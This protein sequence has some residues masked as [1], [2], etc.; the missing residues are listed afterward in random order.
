MMCNIKQSPALLLHLSCTAFLVIPAYG[1]FGIF[2]ILQAKS[3][4]NQK[5]M[6]KILLLL[7][8]GFEMYETSAF[9][10]VIGWN[11]VYGTKDTKLVTCGL[12]KR[13]RSTFSIPIEV[14]VLIDNVN[15]EDFSALA[16]PGGFEVYGYYND[17]YSDKFSS[18]I[19][20]FDRAGK[21]IASICVGALPLAN[22]G[23]LKYRNATTYNCH[24]KQRMEQLQEYN[25]YVL[26]QE[27]V[28]DKNVITSSSPGTAMNVAFKFLEKITD[29]KNTNYIKK[30]MGFG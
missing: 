23:I 16:V 12:R 5:P 17:A 30:I 14:D 6:K 9:I 28:L 18:L 2:F 26:N 19:K 10:D 29:P 7:A 15:H 21:P 25:A 1:Y 8:E 20:D 13:L 27:I 4:K 3:D 24:G 22:S 11:N